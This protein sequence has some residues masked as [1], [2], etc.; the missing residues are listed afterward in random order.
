MPQTA[1]LKPICK[2]TTLEEL[3]TVQRKTVIYGRDAFC[4]RIKIRNY[5]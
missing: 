5:I 1:S 4:Y 2:S 3:N